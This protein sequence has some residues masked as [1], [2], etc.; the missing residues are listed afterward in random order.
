MCLKILNSSVPYRGSFPF[1]N[2]CF[3]IKSGLYYSFPISHIFEINIYR[4]P[5]PLIGFIG[6][7]QN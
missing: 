1:S 7:L 2:I 4:V 6:K 5:G 3:I